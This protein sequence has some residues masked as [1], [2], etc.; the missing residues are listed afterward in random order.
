LLSGALS[1]FAVS[2]PLFVPPGEMVLYSLMR[3]A[4]AAALFVAVALAKDT[5][6]KGGAAHKA[7]NTSKARCQKKSPGA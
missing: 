4:A 1:I 6:H 2:A 3:I 5:V 7:G